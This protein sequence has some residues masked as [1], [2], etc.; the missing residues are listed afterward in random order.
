MC[1]NLTQ[2]ALVLF[3]AVDRRLLFAIPRAG[4]TWIGTTDTDYEGDPADAR[5][6][7]SDVEYLVASVVGMF[8]NLT[9]NDVRYTTAGVRA[10][11]TERGRP[12]T[13][14]RMHRIAE[15][16]PVQG[17][18]SIL[19]GKIT[20]YRAI[21]EDAVDAVCGR[22][23]VTARCSTA[24]TPLPGARG[25]DGGV[26]QAPRFLREIYGSRANPGLGSRGVSARPR[27]A[28]RGG[29]SRHRGAGYLRDANGALST[30]LGF[31]QTAHAAWGVGRSG[32]DRRGAGGRTDGRGAEVA[33]AAACGRDRELPPRCRIHDG[34]P[35]FP[36]TASAA[37]G[38]TATAPQF[39]HVLG[40]LTVFRAIFA[41]F[42][43]WLDR[44]RTTRMS[45]LLRL[46]H[47]ASCSQT[48][49]SIVAQRGRA[50]T[51]K[52][53]R[54]GPGATAIR[55]VRRRLARGRPA[56]A[57]S[58]GCCTSPCARRWAFRIRRRCVRADGARYCVEKSFFRMDMGSPFPTST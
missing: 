45:A 40:F 18:I 32:V 36:V 34:I 15:D 54:H 46:V 31:R 43:V 13:V 53:R 49:G 24:E 41:E 30:D 42:T 8:P 5:A 10:L 2:H 14:S 26:P 58:G 57:G 33:A 12:S 28:A 44:A 39:R 4:Q 52:R 6:T 3:S 19:G 51:L 29:L 20:G 27:P 35:E 23:K 55:R 22:L 25:D 9:V 21:A 47:N 16:V 17:T 7:P 50:G 48:Y 1:P 38:V 11:V 56:R 37:A